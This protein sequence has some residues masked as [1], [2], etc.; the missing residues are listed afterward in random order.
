MKLTPFYRKSLFA[1]LPLFLLIIGFQNCQGKFGLTPISE[2]VNEGAKNDSNSLSNENSGV[3]EE[4]PAVPPNIIDISVPVGPVSGASEPQEPVMPADPNKI[5]IYCPDQGMEDENL[6]CQAHLSDS[7]LIP[8][9]YWYFEDEPATHF[10]IGKADCIFASIKSG[11]RYVFAARVVTPEVTIK[12]QRYA[13][14]IGAAVRG[15]AKVL[16]GTTALVSG[17]PYK[18]SESIVLCL[19]NINNEPTRCIWT[20][21]NEAAVEIYNSSKVNDKII[22]AITPEDKKL[23]IKLNPDYGYFRAA[24]YNASN[25]LIGR[26]GFSA[27]PNYMNLTGL[28]N[29]TP[30]KIKVFAI[31]NKK[32]IIEVSQ[33]SGS[34]VP[35]TALSCPYTVLTVVTPSENGGGNTGLCTGFMHAAAAGTNN[36]YG[37]SA[38]EDTGNMTGDQCVGG[39]RMGAH[40]NTLTGTNYG[41]C[42]HYCTIYAD[43]GADGKWKNLKHSW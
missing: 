34:T 28:T 36:N 26:T 22:E 29:N 11:T 35:T 8:S 6:N 40:Y 38:E 20:P 37:K 12:S 17:G 25:E 7:A 14:D 32:A 31:N 24:A 30:Y 15:T 39:N 2:P 43:C 21:T 10:C 9:L 18:L 41:T 13:I 19:S 33:L 3:T 27:N 23:V 5:T 4:P 16:I 1:I 42:H